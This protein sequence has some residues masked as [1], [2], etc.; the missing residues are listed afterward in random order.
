VGEAFAWLRKEGLFM[1][2]KNSPNGGRNRAAGTLFSLLVGVSL[3]GLTGCLSFPEEPTA[4]PGMEETVTQVTEVPTEPGLPTETATLMETET[5]LATETGESTL[6][7]TETVLP[8]ETLTPE[9]TETFTGTETAT[10]VVPGGPTETESATAEVT[11]APVETI[12]PVVT[13]TLEETVLPPGAGT[14]TIEATETIS[15]AE[16]EQAIQTALINARSAG[17]YHFEMTSTAQ[18]S[19]V[20][21][22]TTG[23]VDLPDRYHVVLDGQELLIVGSSTYLKNNGQWTQYPLDVS[24]LLGSVLGPLSGPASTSMSDFQFLGTDSVNGAPVHIYQYQLN[25][26]LNGSPVLTTVQVWV[27]DA[28]QLPVR[29]EIDGMF[30]GSMAHIV[31]DMTYDPTIVIEE[32]GS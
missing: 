8:E 24:S 28:Q 3:L 13:E 27:D 21:V 11:V 22:S 19:D 7:T 5:P 12:T 14:V 25:A 9:M 30:M 1:F 2:L 10:E 26:D 18:G 29:Q 6:T 31:V 32:P 4:T 23:E 17:P 20:S 15:P 16:A